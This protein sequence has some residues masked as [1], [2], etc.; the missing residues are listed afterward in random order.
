M[1]PPSSD[2]FL[3]L[4]EEL[5]KLDDDKIIEESKKLCNE[6]MTK[7]PSDFIYIVDDS[8]GIKNSELHLYGP[9]EYQDIGMFSGN[10]AHPDFKYDRAK[11]RNICHIIFLREDSVVKGV[12]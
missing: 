7:N 9:L 3:N 5:A 11:I 2:R 6:N 1:N 10:P 12:N 4:L 8:K